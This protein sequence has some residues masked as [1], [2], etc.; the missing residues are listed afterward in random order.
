MDDDLEIE[1]NAEWGKEVRRKIKLKK[2]A[3]RLFYTSARMNLSLYL[4]LTGSVF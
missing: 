1:S 3:M 4:T 2:A